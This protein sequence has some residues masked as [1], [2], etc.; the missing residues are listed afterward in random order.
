MADEAD[1]CLIIGRDPEN[2][3]G[4]H[5]IPG[6]RRYVRADGGEFVESSEPPEVHGEESADV[7]EAI[8]RDSTAYKTKIHQSM[9]KFKKS[10]YN[11]DFK[12]KLIDPPTKKERKEKI[13]IPTKAETRR[14]IAAEKIRSTVT[15]EELE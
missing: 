13:K 7:V 9:V 5:D 12:V 3:H 2:R 8:K 1:M 6:A 4:T 14:R 10:Y 11:S 15:Q